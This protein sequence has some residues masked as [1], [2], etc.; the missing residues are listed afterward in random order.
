MHLLSGSNLQKVPSKVHVNDWSSL[1]FIDKVNLM[2][3]HCIY[4]DM[5]YTISRRKVYSSPCN[6]TEV[7][8]KLKRI[9]ILDL[10]SNFRFKSGWYLGR[11]HIFICEESANMK[12]L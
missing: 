12:T 10:H 5:I 11:G 8:P 6:G 9:R 3:S 4:L 7:R 2:L 1:D